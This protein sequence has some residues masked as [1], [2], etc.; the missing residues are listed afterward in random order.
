MW[1]TPVKVAVW[2]CA[3]RIKRNKKGRRCI[4]IKEPLLKAATLDA[5]NQLIESHE[6]AGKQ[7]KANIMKIVKNSKG[8]TIEELDKRLEEA[9]LKLI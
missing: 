5:I 8:P 2:R 7:I 1:Y 6:L 4:N 3:S 9:Q